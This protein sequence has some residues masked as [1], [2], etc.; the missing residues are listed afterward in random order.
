MPRRRGFIPCA[1]NPFVSAFVQSKGT[2]RADRYIEDRVLFVRERAAN[3]YTTGAYFTA[4]LCVE[5]RGL[6][7]APV[8]CAVCLWRSTVGLCAIYI[9]RATYNVAR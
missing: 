8:L 3:Y 7:C 1:R 5:V 6:G 2:G 9:Y 4:T